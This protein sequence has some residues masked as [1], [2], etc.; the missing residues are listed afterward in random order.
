MG[1]LI[2]VRENWFVALQS[3]SILGGLFFT[4]IS[5]RVDTKARR[6][7]NLITLTQQHR[8]IWTQL[9]KRPELARVLDRAVILHNAPITREEELFVTLLILHLSSAFHAMQAGLF[10]TPQGLSEDI[11][12]FFSLPIPKAVWSEVQRLQ[13]ADFVEFVE[14]RGNAGQRGWR[15]IRYALA[16]HI[17]QFCV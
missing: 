11:I 17:R 12:Q 14:R 8:D 10:M 5:F 16:K 3:L 9:Y 13:D 1:F 15:R 6:I 4:A 7:G 2:W